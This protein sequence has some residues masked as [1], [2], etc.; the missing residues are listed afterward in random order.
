M[1]VR[2]FIIIN[3]GSGGGK[4]KEKS[5]AILELLKRTNI[6]F[7]YKLTESLEDAYTLSA[8]GNKRGYDVIVAVGGDGTINRVINGFYDSAGRRIS[9]AKL[10]VIH[11]GT[12]PDLCK[13]YNIPLEIDKALAAV[14]VGKSKK[15]SLGKITYATVYDQEL[16]GQPIPIGKL[17][18]KNEKFQTGYFACCANIGLG[19]EVARSANS[20]IRRYLGDFAGTLISLIRT[21]LKYHPANFSVSVDGRQQVFEKV[22]NISVGKTTYIASGIK[23]NNELTFGDCRFYSLIIKDIDLFNWFGVLRKIYSGKRFAN[24]HTMSLQYAS[25]LE[26]YGNNRNPELEFDGDPRGFLPCVIENAQDLLDLICEV[27]NE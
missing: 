13:S 26:V 18:I 10:G 14:F 27:Q 23:V 21:L 1:P 11:T 6:S 25:S 16:N 4:S 2:Y 24:D 7:E 12:S 22:H 5:K 8:E 9:G 15:I 17:N 3:P 20:G 19:A